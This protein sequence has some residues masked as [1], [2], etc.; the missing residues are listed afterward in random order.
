MDKVK[1]ALI[2]AGN[3]SHAHIQSYRKMENVEVYAICDINEQRLNETADEYG[4]T[5]RYTDVDTMLADLPEL[6]AADVCVW[7]CNHAECAI[8]ALNAGLHVMCEKPMAYN[9][10]QAVAMQ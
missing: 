1:I 5:R 8:K 4:I 2:G 9:A 6:D 10:Q 7:N 3:I